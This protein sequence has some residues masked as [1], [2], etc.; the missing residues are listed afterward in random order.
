MYDMMGVTMLMSIP[1]GVL[2]GAM[3]RMGWDSRDVRLDGELL[4][5]LLKLLRLWC[6]RLL[7]LVLVSSRHLL[8]FLVLILLVGIAVG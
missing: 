3:T 8:S 6:L 2:W 5:L 7:L 4:L 1:R